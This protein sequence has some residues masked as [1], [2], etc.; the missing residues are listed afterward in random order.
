MTLEKDPL[1]LI[2]TGVGGQGNVLASQI[3]A[4]AGIKDGFYVTVGETYGASQRGGGVLSHVRFSLQT[5]C[6]P[7]T[8]EGQA[9]IV[10]GMEPME[11]LR[12]IADFG[13]PE[14][15]VIVSPRPIYPIW[16]L[17]G[18][19]TYPPIED[20]LGGLREL[21]G[22]VR[23]IEPSVDG[24]TPLPTNV[25]MVGALAGSGML[26]ISLSSFEEALKEI[27]APKSLELNLEAFK[28][29]L[30]ATAT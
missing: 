14:T 10:I 24:G 27:I 3:V 5:Q 25:L 19:A 26:P 1:N 8:P 23:V 21:T 7:L 4:T 30:E 15:R 2:I 18:Q 12:V 29:G 6:G 13:N 11:A 28:K 20:V 16:V 17:S 9:D 22:E